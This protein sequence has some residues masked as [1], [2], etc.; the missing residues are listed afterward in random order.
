MRSARQLTLNP[1]DDIEMIG[2]IQLSPDR[3]QIGCFVESIVERFA[4]NHRVDSR[5]LCSHAEIGS[6]VRDMRH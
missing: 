4:P 2:L 5:I 1:A 6:G 3:G